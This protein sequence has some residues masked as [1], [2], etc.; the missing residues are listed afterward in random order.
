VVVGSREGYRDHHTILDR[1]GTIV[2]PH[3]TGKVQALIQDGYL[4]DGWQRFWDREGAGLN[5]HLVGAVVAIRVDGIFATFITSTRAGPIGREEPTVWVEAT[6]Y[7]D[8]ARR[9]HQS[10]WWGPDSRWGQWTGAIAE[11]WRVAIAGGVHELQIFTAAGV[12]QRNVLAPRIVGLDFEPRHVS[13]HGDRWV[14][15]GPVPTGKG[16]R[17]VA[18]EQD[19]R[20]VWRVDLPFEAHQPAVWGGGDRAY[21]A[22]EGIA[23]LD[24]G[25]VEWSTPRRGPA[26]VTA[27]AGGELALAVGSS[28]EVVGRDGTVLQ[29]FST[30]G[31]ILT[32]PAI[33]GDGSV[34]VATSTSL[35]RGAP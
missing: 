7:T 15:L 35:F 2:V 10:L 28:L 26:R 24:G 30:D 6:R 1:D 21:V 22:G 31:E 12:D 25:H 19:G 9:A 20:E 27:F 17:A 34:F 8:E 11:D 33:A 23:A 32:R 3:Q 14:V 16:T 13:S 5:A 18:F 4:L 29:A